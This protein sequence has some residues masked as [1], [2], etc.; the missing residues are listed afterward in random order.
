MKPLS[1]LRLHPEDTPAF[2]E[3]GEEPLSQGAKGNVLPGVAAPAAKG[4]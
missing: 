4:H 1:S 2:Q 3:E